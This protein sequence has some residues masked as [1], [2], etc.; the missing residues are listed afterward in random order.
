MEKVTHRQ[1]L[2]R[3]VTVLTAAVLAAACGKSSTDGSRPGGGTQPTTTNAPAPET[4]PTDSPPKAAPEEKARAVVKVDPEPSRAPDEADAAFKSR[5]EQWKRASATILVDR[6]REL[7]VGTT[8][9]KRIEV[10]PAKYR[11]GTFD[12]GGFIEWEP[13]VTKSEC[14]GGQYRWKE[15]EPARYDYFPGHTPADDD[16]LLKDAAEV[17]GRLADVVQKPDVQAVRARVLAVAEKVDQLSFLTGEAKKTEARLAELKT[18]RKEISEFQAV[19]VASHGDGL[20]EVQPFVTE[21]Y[22]GRPSR[23]PYGKHALVRM[24]SKEFTS[25]GTTWIL[26]RKVGE[27]EIK[28][29]DGFMET[30]NIYEDADAEAKSLDTEIREKTRFSGLLRK[31]QQALSSLD[32]DRKAVGEAVQ[33]VIVQYAPATAT[34]AK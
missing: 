18:K 21:I 16:R 30:W 17:L 15:V 29:T 28:T 4:K 6:L 20:Y 3:W 8:V 19:V 9:G 1:N 22:Y 34:A 33:R 13:E 26:A 32:K 23:K 12:S 14:T 5:H 2:K 10:S 31:E 7:D 24:T 25:K 11:C 27:K